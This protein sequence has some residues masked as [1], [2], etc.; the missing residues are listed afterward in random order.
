MAGPPIV[1]VD[2]GGAG[3]GYVVAAGTVTISTPLR[4]RRGDTLLMI[5]A[6]RSGVNPLLTVDGQ[7]DV[8]KAGWDLVTVVTASDTLVVLRRRVVEGEPGAHVAT[9]TAGIAGAAALIAYRG[10]DAAAPVTGAA[11]NDSTATTSHV[12][13]S[14]TLAAYSSLYLG[15]V[16]LIDATGCTPPAG[17]TQRLASDDGTRSITIVELLPETAVSTG[18]K[19]ATTA[20]GRTGLAASLQLIAGPTV[21]LDKAF[22][23]APIGSI[24]L[25]SVGV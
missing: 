4:V 2:A 15:I 3:A 14:Q 13:P 22:T 19:T 6:F 11:V 23:I 9:F 5:L 10:V 21:G 18:T 7:A 24:G 16:M 1:F 20:A 25:P 17:V 12:M 8:T